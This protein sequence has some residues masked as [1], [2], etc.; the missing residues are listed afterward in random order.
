M[1]VV[2][3]FKFK[4][5]KKM[6][7]LL[8]I[9]SV[10]NSGSTGRIAEE[11]GCLAISKGWDS[12]I[13]YGRNPRK[14][15]SKL[16]KIGNVYEF[17][18]HALITRL[19]DRHG[20]GSNFATKK[21]IQQIKEINPD[22]IHLHN[23]H[24]YYLNIKILFEFLSTLDK[25]IVWTLH[26]CWPFTGHCSH[27]DLIKCEK[28]KTSCKQCPQI[29]EYP[30]SLFVDNS[31]KNYNFKKELFQSL[32][33][34]TLVPVSYWLRNIVKKSFL[35]EANTKV[36]YNG[37]DTSVFNISP[38][39]NDLKKSMGIDNK[40]IIL[41]VANVWSERKGLKDFLKL[42]EKLSDQY[43]IV[44]VGLSSKQIKILPSNIIGIE[45]T[46]SVEQLAELYS[47]ADV[48]L[49]PT[50]EDNFPTTNLEALAC[51]TPIISYNT[52]GSIEAVSA[53]SGFIVDKGNIEELINSINIVKRKGKSFYQIACRNRAITCYDK[54]DRFNE[55][56]ELY[57]QLISIR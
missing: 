54:N 46:E 35:Y 57:N 39:S 5:I 15:S 2:Y 13:A 36:I 26:D 28:W 34:I 7:I 17:Y 30:A 50:W 52:G 6:P 12:Y 32:N 14:S 16:I 49:N 48:Y 42:S 43:R 40:F 25:P 18:Q 10:V 19:F 8:Q 41:G 33:N 21:F 38:T 37:I 27:F 24:G 3:K 20:L 45:R 56:I 23:I 31:K 4:E 53:D 29:N 44:L 22:I 1:Y 9:N 55:Y 11:I 47:A 51:G